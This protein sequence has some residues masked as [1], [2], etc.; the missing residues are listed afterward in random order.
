M[1][2]ILAGFCNDRLAIRLFGCTKAL[3]DRLQQTPKSGWIPFTG[4]KSLTTVRSHRLSSADLLDS[5]KWKRNCNFLFV[6][7]NLFMN[8]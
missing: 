1:P 3:F 5:D 2:C 8:C 4:Q 7:E 6:I